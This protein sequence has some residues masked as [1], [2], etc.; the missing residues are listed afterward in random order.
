MVC[1]QNDKCTH[2]YR[3]GGRGVESNIYQRGD[4]HEEIFGDIGSWG[5][6]RHMQRHPQEAEIHSSYMQ[7]YKIMALT[8]KYSVPSEKFLAKLQTT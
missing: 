4:N 1:K 7:T 5:Y 2:I 8:L 6:E 3:G